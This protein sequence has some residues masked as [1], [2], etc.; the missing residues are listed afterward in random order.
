M[1]SRAEHIDEVDT[2]IKAQMLAAIASK[3]GARM[4]AGNDPLALAPKPMP[5]GLCGA[6][7]YEQLAVGSWISHRERDGI[8]KVLSLEAWCGGCG[9][10]VALPD[11]TRPLALERGVG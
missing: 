11:A 1:S 5:C 2:L 10:L 6:P 7:I 8:A 3:H 9:L 4:L